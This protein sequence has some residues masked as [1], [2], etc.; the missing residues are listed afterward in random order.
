MGEGLARGGA[1]VL[2][3]NRETGDDSFFEDRLGPGVAMDRFDITYTAGR[4]RRTVNGYEAKK[5]RESLAKLG[6]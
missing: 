3:A 4:R 2:L 5:A 6:G 1:R